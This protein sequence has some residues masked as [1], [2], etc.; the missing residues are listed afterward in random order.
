[1]RCKIIIP[2]WLFPVL[3]CSVNKKLYLGLLHLK[4]LYDMMHLLQSTRMWGW[5]LNGKNFPVHGCLQKSKLVLWMP[6]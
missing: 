1:M 4:F 5:K 3:S 2:F 6:W